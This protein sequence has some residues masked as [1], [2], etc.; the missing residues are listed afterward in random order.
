MMAGHKH[1]FATAALGY[2][3]SGWSPFPLP[4][5]QK[6]PPPDGCTGRGGENYDRVRLEREAATVPGAN[7]GLRMAKDMIGIDV[8]AYG[9]KNGWAELAELQRRLGE[10]PD[11]YIST[12]RADGASGIRFYRVPEGLKWPGKLGKSIEVLQHA[13]RY[14]VVWPSVHPSGKRYRWYFGNWEPQDRPPSPTQIPE[15][16]ARWVETIT[17]GTADDGGD[18]KADI[19]D[20]ETGHVFTAG[21]A[22][23]KTAEALQGYLGRKTA[24]ARHDAMLHTQLDLVRLGERGHRGVRESLL[25]LRDQFVS[26]VAEDRTGGKE[27][28]EFQRGIDGA[29]QIVYAT[30]TPERER[31]CRCGPEAAGLILP[32][33]FY[34][35]RPCLKEIQVYAHDLCAGAD[36]VLYA[37]LARYSAMVPPSCRVD[38]GILTPLSLNLFVAAMGPAGGGKSS[39]ATLSKGVYEA[40]R[41]MRHEDGLPLGSGEGLIETYFETVWEDDTSKPPKANGAPYQVKVKKKTKSHAFFVSDEGQAMVKLMERNGATL[42]ETIRS[43]WFAKTAGQNN[44]NAETRRTLDEHTYA[45]GMLV[46]FQP[47][48]VQPLLAASEAGTPQ[49]FLFCWVIDPNIPDEPSSPYANTPDP[50]RVSP[51]PMRVVQAVKAEIRATHLARTRGLETAPRMDAHDYAAKA[52]LAALLALMDRRHEVDEEDWRLAGLVYATS[53]AVRDAMVQY[54]KSQN[55]RTAEERNRAHADRE[56]MAETARQTARE[57]HSAPLRVARKIARL[58]HGNGGLRTVGA[59]NRRLGRDQQDRGLVESAW[60]VA[61]G[62]DWVR[63]DEAS[64]EPG[65]S[66]PS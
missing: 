59:V 53:S 50:V 47:S 26:D 58:V 5:G 52:K 10:L 12:S 39:S 46:G 21:T 22:C 25:A 6:D 35:S 13:H 2:Y 24:E 4:A 45:A 62:E 8:D 66:V 38:T 44:A 23:R 18:P 49:R 1:V 29:L 48:T 41:E 14:A 54:G 64:V 40:P 20:V 60:D 16:P 3:D 57:T 65:G 43:L 34:D 17:G 37:T 31:G 11:T 42:G 7:I 51:K 61:V 56:A 55:A 63:V 9:Q 28:G 32:Q 30:P 27:V 19:R 36:S 33:E 15:L